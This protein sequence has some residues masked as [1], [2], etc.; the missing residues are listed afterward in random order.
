MKKQ[1]KQKSPP[2]AF[3]YY[4]RIIGCDNMALDDM[5]LDF[6]EDDRESAD[7][8]AAKEASLFGPYAHAIFLKV[9]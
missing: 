9:I 3:K 2:K 1:K 8:R 7:K 6:R 5:G 4:Y